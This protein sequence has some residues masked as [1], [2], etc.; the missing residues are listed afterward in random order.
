[1]FHGAVTVRG[2]ASNL[3]FLVNKSVALLLLLYFIFYSWIRAIKTV[4]T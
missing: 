2:V 1:M 3:F 4:F